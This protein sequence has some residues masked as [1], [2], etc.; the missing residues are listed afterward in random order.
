[1]SILVLKAFCVSAA[2]NPPAACWNFDD[3][4][5]N[6][7]TGYAKYV[8]GVRGSALK[9][10]GFTTRVT[11]KS[12]ASIDMANGFTVEAWVAPQT[13][14]WNW[15][16]I[17]DREKDHL[18]GFSF[19]INHIG[20]VGLSLAVGGKWHT[21]LSEKPIPLLKWSHAAVTYDAA[22]RMAVYVNGQPAGSNTIRGNPTPSRVELWI[23]MSHTR[24]YPQLTERK[25]SME[26]LSRMV[27]D[28]LIDEVR[29][30]DRAQPAEEIKRSF[31]AVTPP[32]RRPLSYR[33][34][35][36][37]PE[38]INVFGA[39]YTRLK[40]APEWERIWRV[41]DHADVLV[42]FDESPVRMVFWR[43][44]GYCPAWV[45]NNDKWVCDQGPESWNAYGCCEQMS[46]K[47]CHYAHVRI[48]ENHDAR[49]VV[50]W[51]TASPDITYSFNHVDPNTGWGEWTDEYYY[52]Y[53]DAV[54]VRYQQIRS[55]WAARMEWQQSELLNQPGTKPQDNIETSA[56]TLV[57]LDGHTNTYSWDVKYG[58]RLPAD[59]KVSGPIQVMNL[60]SA[61]RHFV[62]GESGASWR[63]CRF[64]ARNGYSNMPCWNH[65]PVAQLP[66]DGRVTP[67][68]DR[69]SSTCLGTLFPVKHKTYRDDLMIG[70]NLYGMTDEDPTSLAVLARSWN[71]PAKLKLH[72]ES[73]TSAGYDKN[74]RAYILTYVGN[75]KPTPLIFDIEASQ[76]SPLVN[77]A[78]VI[79]NWGEHKALLTVNDQAVKEGKRFRVGYRRGLD[80]IDL[81]AWIKIKSLEPVKVSIGST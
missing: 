76:K 57:D 53:P 39:F 70:R 49:A 4:S 73:F 1:M 34:M 50:H 51:R 16:G 63:A 54:A 25:P 30:H 7:V 71:S 79:K 3:G 46:D 40:Y 72:G 81:I 62:I 56:I 27:F 68:P 13:Y 58:R 60:K 38:K 29:I 10:D 11:H 19:G 36:S 47:R 78:C 12:D 6:N 35:P 66:N 33:K 26:F 8:T 14:S 80:G 75:G 37:G 61:Y 65:W 69:P 22:G 9:F 44:T 52:V 55:T 17:V 59:K 48:L 2:E 77:F 32:K 21:L 67:A 42:T 24:Q 28:G 45:T 23:G 74:Q 20:Q 64:G 15:T 43:G 41:G 5:K 31:A 18:E